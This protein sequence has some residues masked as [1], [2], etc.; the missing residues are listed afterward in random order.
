M[1]WNITGW[2]AERTS[3]EN[4]SLSSIKSLSSS[5][6]CIRHSRAAVPCR[7]FSLCESQS[8]HPIRSVVNA[9]S[10]LILVKSIA[11]SLTANECMSQHLTSSKQWF[12][13]W[14]Q[15]RTDAN[16]FQSMIMSFVGSL[17]PSTVAIRANVS[18]CPSLS[19][20]HEVATCN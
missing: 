1:S 19:L 3:G 10:E 11:A 12:R 20:S 13:Q 6:T 14:T 16:L 15:T 9:N 17:N 18:N 7:V 5:C 2:F 4:K 8:P